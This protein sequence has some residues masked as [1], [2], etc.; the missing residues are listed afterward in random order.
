M[1]QQSE[2]GGPG[3]IFEG[4]QHAR[5]VLERCRLG[6]SLGQRAR[7]FTLEIDDEEIVRHDQHLT[8]VI[9]AMDPGLAGPNSSSR[10]LP[11]GS[12]ALIPAGQYRLN[13]FAQRPLCGGPGTVERGEAPARPP[14]SRATPCLW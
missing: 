2:Q 4:P 5:D 11:D 13:R 14:P 12:E 9:V 6:A 8:E 3:R 1:L 10:Q 7:G